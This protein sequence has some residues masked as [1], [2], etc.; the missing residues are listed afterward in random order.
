MIGFGFGL[1]EEDAKQVFV[2]STQFGNK[3]FFT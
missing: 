2:N 1:H 3:S